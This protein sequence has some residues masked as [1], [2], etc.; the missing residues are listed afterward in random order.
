MKFCLLD[1]NWKKVRQALKFVDESF[2]DFF[3]ITMNNL[4]KI[5][6]DEQD[7]VLVNFVKKNRIVFMLILEVSNNNMT[8]NKKKN[9]TTNNNS[10]NNNRFY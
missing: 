4:A 7:V 2:G 5:V 8:N 3:D 10:S 1:F 6:A 9:K